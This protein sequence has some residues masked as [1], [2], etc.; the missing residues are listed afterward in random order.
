LTQITSVVDKVLLI[1]MQ[2]ISVLTYTG[3]NNQIV[4]L[5]VEVWHGEESNIYI[6]I[7]Q[8]SN[9]MHW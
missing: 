7:V 2:P 8:P 5:E 1:I 4:P 6:Y 9:T 3:I